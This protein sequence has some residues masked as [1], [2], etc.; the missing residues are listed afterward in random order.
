MTLTN[1]YPCMNI[2]T[3]LILK[4]ND[5]DKVFWI[6]DYDY[7]LHV[8]IYY[9]IMI[10]NTVFNTLKRKIKKNTIVKQIKLKNIN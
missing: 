6:M 1:Y 7:L 10:M 8:I 9:S 5:N 4:E 3:M 2:D